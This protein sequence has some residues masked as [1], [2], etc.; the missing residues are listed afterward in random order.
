MFIFAVILMTGNLGGYLSPAVNADEENNNSYPNNMSASSCSWLAG[1][2][3]ETK[4]HERKAQSG[5]KETKKQG[6]KAQSGPL[7]SA[8]T[9]D[10]PLNDYIT[11]VT[12]SGTTKIEDNLYQ[13]TVELQFVIDTEFIKAVK[14]AGYKFV[15]VLPEEV[16]LNEG[17]ISGGPYY[18]YLMDRYPELEL[19]FT[20]DYVPTGDGHYRIEIVYDD[21]FVQDA[22][23]SG[24]DRIK[25]TLSCRCW[26]RSSGDVGHD[27]LNVAFT[28]T[29]TLHILPE[30]I[31]EDYDITT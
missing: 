10:V 18:A 22:T 29:K 26:I 3:K 8:P 21:H 7:R 17:L 30:D 16:V 1:K 20:Y 13:A 6:R 23:E 31:N 27:G 28:D 9:N 15:Y 5:Q 11:G 24:T 12:A 19:A 25:N 14:S 4:K 2:S